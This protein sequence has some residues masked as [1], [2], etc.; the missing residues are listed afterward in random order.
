[1]RG[2]SLQGETYE[3]R[4]GEYSVGVTLPPRRSE[5]RLLA[6][7]LSALAD[8]GDSNVRL[9]ALDEAAQERVGERPGD[10]RERGEPLRADEGEGRRAKGEGAL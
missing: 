10:E 4:H 6:Q 3:E 9:A 8:H 2:H 5:R 7:G 1:M